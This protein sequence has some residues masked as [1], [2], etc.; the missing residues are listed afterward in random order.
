MPFRDEDMPSIVA[1]Y[2]AP[3]EGAAVSYHFE[4]PDYARW[5]ARWSDVEYGSYAEA[6]QANA[7][8]REQQKPKHTDARMASARGVLIDGRI[9]TRKINVEDD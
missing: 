2:V 3:S 6:V 1:R 7:A 4:D 5:E 9:V 8:R